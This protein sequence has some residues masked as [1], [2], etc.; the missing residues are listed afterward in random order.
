MHP[1]AQGHHLVSRKV[2]SYTTSNFLMHWLVCTALKQSIR[3]DSFGQTGLLRVW[4]ITIK[5]LLESK[6]KAPTL[7]H[8]SPNH[9]LSH[10]SLTSLYPSHLHLH[11]QQRAVYRGSPA[12]PPCLSLCAE[13]GRR[14]PS[15]PHLQEVLQCPLV[16]LTCLIL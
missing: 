8:P 7:S 14:N 2:H 10:P 1:T 13:Q 11:S 15:A 4:R 5:V 12:V 3:P 16:H 6:T 9:T